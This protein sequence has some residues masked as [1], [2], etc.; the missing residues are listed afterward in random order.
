MQASATDR[1]RDRA[2]GP[3]PATPVSLDAI[4]GPLP[5]EVLPAIAK[6]SAAYD[7]LAALGQHVSFEIDP[8]TGRVEVQVQDQNGRP[9]AEL[10][11]SDVLRLA[12]GGE[13][14]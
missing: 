6:A 2:A 10:S 13:L 3:D 7:V 12:E 1:L 9:I 4:P 11:P 8:A 14:D 5:L